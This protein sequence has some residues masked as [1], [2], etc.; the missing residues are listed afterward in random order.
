MG[1]QMRRM[2]LARAVF[3]PLH[4][5]ANG[6][7]PGLIEDLFETYRSLVGLVIFLYLHSPNVPSCY[8]TH[9][10]LFASPPASVF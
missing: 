1:G 10:A 7:S 4:V 9:C 2:R 3:D 6:L 8:C 5:K